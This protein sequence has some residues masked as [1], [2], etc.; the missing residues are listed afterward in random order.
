MNRNFASMILKPELG[1]FEA[2]CYDLDAGRNVGVRINYES[3]LIR[4]IKYGTAPS[5]SIY[6]PLDFRICETHYGKTLSVSLTGKPLVYF[7]Y[8]SEV[9]EGMDMY[10]YLKNF[11]EEFGPEPES[12]I[13]FLYFNTLPDEYINEE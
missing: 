3:G 12:D 10:V 11:V 6:L 5:Y 1:W 2:Y 4:V 7:D 13:Q 8:K 9:F